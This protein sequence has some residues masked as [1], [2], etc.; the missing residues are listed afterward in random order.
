MKKVIWLLVFVS[1]AS[2]KLM[3]QETPEFPD[4][5]AKAQINTRI[6]NLRYDVTENAIFFDFEI[7]KG[8]RYAEQYLGSDGTEV[9]DIERHVTLNSSNVRLD[10]YLEPGVTVNKSSIVVTSTGDFGISTSLQT[11]GG[12]VPNIPTNFSAIRFGFKM[13]RNNNEDSGYNPSTDLTDSYVKVITCKIPVTAGTPT[14]ESYIK[15]KTEISGFGSFWSTGYDNITNQPFIPNKPQYNLGCPVHVNIWTGETSNDWNTE[16]NWKSYKYDDDD[17]VAISATVP[18]ECTDVYIPGTSILGESTY[19][20][21]SLTGVKADNLCNRIFFLPGAQ[22]GRPDLLTYTEAHV[23]LDF[24]KGSLA[25]QSKLT[26]TQFVALGASIDSEA[27]VK[28]GAQY[29]AAPLARGSWHMLSAPLNELFSG[30]LTFGGF[31]YS[32]I[33][34]FD[35]DGSSNSYILG[36]WAE[37]DSETDLIFKPGQG[38]GHFYFPYATGTPYGMD[39]S[40]GGTQWN[41]AKTSSGVTAATPTHI[42][43]DDTAFGLAQSNGILHLPFFADEY[44][45]DAHR[46]HEY[47]EGVSTFNFVFRNDLT[48]PNFLQWSGE[49][50]EV[51]RT[52]AAHRFIFEDEDW[53][54][55]FTPAGSY[56]AGDVVLVGNPYMSALD[57]D[58]FYAENDDK[59]K[60][61]YHIYKSPNTYATYGTSGLTGITSNETATKFI[62]PMQSVLLEVAAGVNKAALTLTFDPT[63]AKTS[64]GVNLRASN[65]IKDNLLTITASNPNGTSSTWLRRS[66][67][68][69]DDFCNEDF[70]KII[71]QPNTAPVVYTLVPTSKGESRALLLNSVNSDDLIVP[72][73]MA[74]TYSGEISLD[75]RGMDNYDARVYLIDA[76]EKTSTEISKQ[77]VFT[78]SFD[79]KG[80][81]K[82]SLEN[83][84]SLR[85][86]PKS[87]TGIDSPKETKI[88]AYTIENDLI[89]VSDDSDPILSLTIYDLQGRNIRQEQADKT[90][91]CKIENAFPAPGVYI[92]KV[93]TSQGVRDLKIIR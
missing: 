36:N 58:E 29:S 90:A 92:L 65:E 45:S 66:A 3:A 91:F 77:S 18:E 21:P 42:K 33:H 34:K 73:G 6:V 88:T 44:L 76:I 14:E 60:K 41:A 35:V 15:Q 23:Q 40:A 27:R 16:S 79:Y 52:S 12:S 72:I 51:V 63:M 1:I 48:G 75:I 64:S 46:I 50:E 2:F 83:R 61:V 85:F 89:V 20:F 22:L 54:N 30:D 43:N 7:K 93:R 9:Y 80:E 39:N 53:N 37:F 49:K 62:P 74:S 81:T 78:L 68:A 13:E 17:L 4:P 8:N 84:F 31:P 57:F 86:S 71:N 10:V 25:S 67:E 70:S 32:Y 69:S 47:S 55:Q 82:S 38:F 24:G 11:V 19:P 28:L 56:S 59:I 5:A 26:Y 87:D